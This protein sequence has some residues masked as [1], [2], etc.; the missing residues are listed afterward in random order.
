MTKPVKYTLIAI[1]ALVA[2]IV[3]RKAYDLYKKYKNSDRLSLGDMSFKL[4]EKITLVGLA[5]GLDGT[6][7]VQI[8]NFSPTSFT[9]D[10]VKL[11]L[12][13][14]GGSL[15]A[16]QKAPLASPITVPA[17]QNSETKLDFNIATT[18]VLK[19]FAESGIVPKGASLADLVAAVTALTSLKGV[20]VKLKGF[21]VSEGFKV[22]VDELINLES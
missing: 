9:V 5:D 3:G 12:Y 19:L 18:G 7:K 4:N 13:T 14:K 22:D 21:F 17:N 1:F 16:S 15:L 6:A 11:G 10:Q 2:I 8:K 20:A